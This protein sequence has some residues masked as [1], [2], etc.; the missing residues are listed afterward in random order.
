MV[1]HLN[2]NKEY[3]LS[4]LEKVM[5]PEIPVI[6]VIDMGMI[7]DVLIN[8][9]NVVVKMIPTFTACP[10]IQLIQSNIKLNLEQHGIPSVSVLLDKDVLW[11]SDRVTEKGKILLEDFKL[12]TP[13]KH[14][15]I[16]TDDMIMNSVCPYCG[17]DNTTINAL[18]GSTLCRSLHFCYNCKNKFERFKPVA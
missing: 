14:N 17:S 10:A 7:T 4:L 12:G 5:D 3:V 2:I 16:V 18:F 11:N 1:N 6:S 9:N 8:D 13:I 15:G